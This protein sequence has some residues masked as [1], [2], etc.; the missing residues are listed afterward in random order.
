VAT[1]WS[2]SAKIP[3]GHHA[4]LFEPVL[5]VSAAEQ[6]SA[7]DHMAFGNWRRPG[8]S[9]GGTW[10]IEFQAIVLSEAGGLNCCRVT[11]HSET[12]QR[13]APRAASEDIP[14]D[15]AYIHF[16]VFPA[17]NAWSFRRGSRRRHVWRGQER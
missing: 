16:R 1:A 3:F 11:R 12:G 15:N 5:V 6:G 2:Y 13:R 14:G 8:F 17:D 9:G 7:S 4:A 10:G